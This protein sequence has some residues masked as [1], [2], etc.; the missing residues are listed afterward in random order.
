MK[1]IDVIND[2]V[3][4]RQSLGN[5]FKSTS[6]L[7]RQFGRT[8]GDIEIGEVRPQAVKEFLRGTGPLS[9]TWAVKYKVL[10]GL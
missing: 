5:R 1:L 6:R 4:L 8:M 10:S 2:Y 7:L 3:I 9:A